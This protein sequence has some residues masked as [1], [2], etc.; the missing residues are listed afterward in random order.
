MSIRNDSGNDLFAIGKPT[1]SGQG[2]VVWG[3]RISLMLL[4]ELNNGIFSYRQILQYRLII[5]K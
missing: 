1:L 3:F 5:D 4:G 2:N